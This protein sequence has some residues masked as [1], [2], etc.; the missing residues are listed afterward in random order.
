MNLLPWAVR[1]IVA[2]LILYTIGVWS[3][4]LA[5]RLKAWHLVF[6]WLGLA[7]D[8]AGTTLMGKI[9]G[10]ITLNFHGTTGLVAITLM[11]VHT[12][13]ATVVLLRRDEPAIVSF[14]RFSVFVW[15]VWLVPFVSGVIIGLWR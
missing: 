6:F 3:E 13:W 12:L 5:G 10:G 11:L 4:R 15:T 9:A 8:T 2:A 7:T 1:F 14:H